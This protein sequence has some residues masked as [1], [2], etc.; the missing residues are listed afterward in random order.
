MLCYDLNRPQHHPTANDPPSLSFLPPSLLSF[1]A[2]L[3]LLLLL[4]LAQPSYLYVYKG[5][6][7]R[8]RGCKLCFREE[9]VYT[10]SMDA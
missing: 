10:L 6:K 2:L 4:L 9:A 1:L 8:F 3:S 5:T 7:K